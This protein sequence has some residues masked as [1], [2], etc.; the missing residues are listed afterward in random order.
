MTMRHS[1]FLALLLLAA[2]AFS[3]DAAAGDES[4]QEMLTVTDAH[5]LMDTVRGQV[6]AMISKMPVVMQNVMSEM[7]NLIGPM[8]QKLRQIQRDTLQEIKDST[9]KPAPSAK[10]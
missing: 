6:D 7:K 10:T 4:I 9:A 3:N 1:L 8:Q 5:K 2:P